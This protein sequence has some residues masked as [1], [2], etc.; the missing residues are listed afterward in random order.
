MAGLR[1]RHEGNINIAIRLI[2]TID[3][4]TPHVE[5]R[6][7]RG[8]ENDTVGIGYYHLGVSNAPLLAIHGVEAEKWGELFYNVAVT[9]WFHVT[10]DVQILDPAQQ[11]NS[12]A[13]LVGIRARLSF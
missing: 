2:R 6:S 5:I 7:I 13:L 3:S 4:A 1:I 12:T 11:R 9:P 8:R 10:P